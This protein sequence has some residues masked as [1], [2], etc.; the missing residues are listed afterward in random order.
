MEPDKPTTVRLTEVAKKLKEAHT[1]FYGLKNILSAGLVL[2]DK[3]TDTEQ[4]AAIAEANGLK[5]GVTLRDMILHARGEMT[6]DQ[7][8]Q[9]WSATPEKDR[10]K[11]QSL[12]EQARAADEDEAAAARDTRAAKRKKARRKSSKPRR[13]PE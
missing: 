10:K 5:Q 7:F 1:P 11:F 3:L 13:V 8:Q 9:I 4:K 12:I 2:F 6:D